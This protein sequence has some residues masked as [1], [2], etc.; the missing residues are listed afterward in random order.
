MQLLSFR[1]FTKEASRRY[2]VGYVMASCFLRRLLKWHHLSRL[3]I[4]VFINSG[5][6][7]QESLAKIFQM[8]Q[9]G[10]SYHIAKVEKAFKIRRK[11]KDIL[12]SLKVGRLHKRQEHRVQIKF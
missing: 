12:E 11:E 7:K 1:D 4:V 9:G 6:Y 10:I 5:K 2:K 3:S 8:T